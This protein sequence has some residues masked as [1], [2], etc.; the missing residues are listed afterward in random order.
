MLFPSIS[1]PAYR[2]VV[3]DGPRLTTPARPR[4]SLFGG[5]GKTCWRAT[6]FAID[7]DGAR[8]AAFMGYDTEPGTIADDTRAVCKIRSPKKSMCG[9]PD[10]VPLPTARAECSGQI[11]FVLRDGTVK[12]LV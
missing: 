4:P 9:Q 11:Y 6:C 3:L 5:G 8:V 10:V 12:R 2:F 1:A 7:D